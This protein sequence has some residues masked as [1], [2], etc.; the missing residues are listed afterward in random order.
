MGMDTDTA[1][2][3]RKTVTGLI[4]LDGGVAGGGKTGSGREVSLI[5]IVNRVGVEVA[6]GSALRLREILG[7]E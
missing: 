1:R 2:R 5:A 7:A 3:A 6:D 4:R